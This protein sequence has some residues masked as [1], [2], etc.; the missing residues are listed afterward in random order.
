MS[1]LLFSLE[2]IYVRQDA[3]EP[4]EWGQ[5]LQSYILDLSLCNARR[6]VWKASK[7]CNHGP[8][9]DGKQGWRRWGRYEV[10][11]ERFVERAYMCIT[12]WFHF[13]IRN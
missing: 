11:P 6:R 10:F 1:V 7:I 12:S 4:R 9:G 13:P 3:S 5:V 8:I 2:N